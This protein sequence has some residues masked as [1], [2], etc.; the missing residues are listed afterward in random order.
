MA[1]T[2]SGYAGK[3]LRVDLTQE[4]IWD[5]PLDEATAKAYVGGIGLGAKIL[6]DEVAP[7]IEWSDPENRLIFASGPLGGTTMGG[8]GTFSVITKGAL[9]GGATST[10]ANGFFG[11]F[12]RFCGYDAI[13]VQGAAS[14]W[15]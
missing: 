2:I 1:A 9:T 10:Q 4:K 7:G 5:E 8:S 3:L 11:A 13:V 12:M 15:R 6:Y 14:R